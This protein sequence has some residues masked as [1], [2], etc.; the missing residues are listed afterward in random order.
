M[1]NSAPGKARIATCL[2]PAPPA[3]R[4][5][6]RRA[7]R[8]RSRRARQRAVSHT[9][10]T[11]SRARHHAGAMPVPAHGC[12][13]GANHLGAHY[14]HACCLC[15]GPAAA[16]LAAAGALR[17]HA[18]QQQH[19]APAPAGAARVQ[20][21]PAAAGGAQAPPLD[22]L[23]DAARWRHRPGRPRGRRGRI[24]QRARAAPAATC[25]RRPVAAAGGAQQK[26]PR[27]HQGRRLRRRRRQCDRAHDQHRPA[28]AGC[29]VGR[30]RI[31]TQC[32]S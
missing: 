28:G 6:E 24:Q 22:G 5:L 32:C 14:Q 19:R 27:L 8:L 30:E 15:A 1:P 2:Q 20:R 31:I 16:Q 26:R 18:C 9:R 4:S 3:V 25:R 17:P 12:R 13:A 29:A 21:R 7:N 10:T 23:P 11:G